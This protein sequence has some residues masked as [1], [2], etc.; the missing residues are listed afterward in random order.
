M[1]HCDVVFEWKCTEPDMKNLWDGVNPDLRDTYREFLQGREVRRVTSFIYLSLWIRG[2]LH[3]TPSQE[4]L[5]ASR[6]VREH[7][8][9]RNH[10][11]R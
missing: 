4:R 7:P 3:V 2:H 10:L 5:H 9:Q 11:R 6:A 8:A 1:S